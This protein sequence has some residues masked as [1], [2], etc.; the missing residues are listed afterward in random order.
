MH[1]VARIAARMSRD[2]AMKR[3]FLGDI[4]CSETMGRQAHQS[5]VDFEKF[6][7]YRRLWREFK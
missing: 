5:G 3:Y 4:I 1:P 6:G 7:R 2:P